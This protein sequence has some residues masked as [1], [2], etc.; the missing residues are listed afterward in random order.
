MLGS[1]VVFLQFTN[2]DGF[3]ELVEL[4]QEQELRF[5]GGVFVR[6][7]GPHECRSSEYGNDAVVKYLVSYEAL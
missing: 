7:S 4:S 1:E 5:K 2:C 6:Q 3:E